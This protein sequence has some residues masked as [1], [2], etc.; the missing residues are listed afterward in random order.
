MEQ[1][2]M[3]ILSCIYGPLLIAQIAL[4]LIF[5]VVNEAGFVL[6]L[7]AGWAIWVISVIFGFLPIFVFKRKG[8]VA[9]GKSSVLGGFAI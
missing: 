7:Y 6:V 8:D 1:W 3:Y 5:G 9:K 2:K 4:V